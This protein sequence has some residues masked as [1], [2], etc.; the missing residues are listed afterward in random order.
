MS[1]NGELHVSGAYNDLNFMFDKNPKSI[2]HSKDQGSSA[3]PSVLFKNSIVLEDVRI[4]V[5]D[6]CTERYVDMCLFADNKQIGCTPGD[7]T[8]GPSEWFFF[9]VKYFE[10]TFFD[11]FLFNLS[12]SLQKHQKFI[13]ISRY[14]KKLQNIEK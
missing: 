4:Q 7:F 9:Q 11:F 5:R 1:W 8:I 2:S 6:C 3:G 14:Y 13:V 10:N 12:F